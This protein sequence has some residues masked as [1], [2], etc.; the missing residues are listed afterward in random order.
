MIEEMQ[1]EIVN[2][3]A[4]R[5][6]ELNQKVTDNEKDFPDD[7]KGPVVLPEPEGEIIKTD[8]GLEWKTDS[9]SYPIEVTEDGKTFYKIG[10]QYFQVETGADS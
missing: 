2:R 7:P 1:L 9:A 5:N 3:I 4:S 10:A 6:S 8:S